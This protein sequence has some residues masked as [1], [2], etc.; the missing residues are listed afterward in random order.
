MGGK[1]EG[2]ANNLQ[3]VAKL[4]FHLAAARGKRE[5][6]REGMADGDGT[7][8]DAGNICQTNCEQVPAKIATGKANSVEYDDVAGR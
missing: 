2:H 7:Q 1:D 3:A 5:R 6:G 4:C 8:A